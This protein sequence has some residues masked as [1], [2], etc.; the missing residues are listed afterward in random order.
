MEIENYISAKQFC[1]LHKIEVSF[2][3]SL[4]DL[5]L[6]TTIVHEE[7]HYIDIEK[8][9]DLEKMIRLYYDLDINPEGIEAISHLLKKVNLMQEEIINLKNRIMFLEGE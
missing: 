9:A 2:I 6:V 3:I 4:N 5:G 8:V 1:E 7:V